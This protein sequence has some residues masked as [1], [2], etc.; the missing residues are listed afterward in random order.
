MKELEREG[1]F[2]EIIWEVRGGAWQRTEEDGGGKA[3]DLAGGLP[4]ME[5]MAV[6][7]SRGGGGGL[8]TAASR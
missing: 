8:R 3:A 7:R 5:G 1:N 4:E 2:G 6:R